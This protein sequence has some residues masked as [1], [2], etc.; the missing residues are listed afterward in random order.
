MP[1]ATRCTSKSK[2]NGPGGVDTPAGLQVSLGCA[3]SITMPAGLLSAVSVAHG[4]TTTGPIRPVDAVSP[5]AALA[6]TRQKI[7]PLLKARAGAA[8]SPVSVVSTS[9]DASVL[10]RLTRS[11]YVT[12]MADGGTVPT[13]HANAGASGGS[14]PAPGRG[15]G[16]LTPLG[17]TAAAATPGRPQPQIA[18]G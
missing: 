16:A 7:D 15:A 14:A 11:R 6:S 8:A 9:G 12:G 5:L 10:S 17:K 1:V 3:V 4:G 18:S 2:V 13:V